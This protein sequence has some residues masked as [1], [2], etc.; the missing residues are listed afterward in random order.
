MDVQEAER[1]GLT[2]WVTSLER[3]LV[4]VLDRPDL[5]GGWEETWRL[6]GAIEFVD[7]DRIVSYALE[8]DNAT[9]IAKV[10]FV[11]SQHQDAWMITDR[12]MQ[13]LRD[14]RPR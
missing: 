14:R 13:P 7:I 3:T 4:G 5:A 10:G 6:V 8:L 2:V 12:Q 11:A 1:A 9:T